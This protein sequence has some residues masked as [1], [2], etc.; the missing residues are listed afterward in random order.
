VPAPSTDGNG[1]QILTGIAAI[2]ASDIWAVG[3]G[4]LSA[5]QSC[6]VAAGGTALHWNGAQWSATTLAVPSGPN[7]FGLSLA[8]VTAAASNNV[9]AVGG[10]GTGATPLIEHWNG[11]AWSIVPGASLTTTHGLEGVAALP[12]G[13]VWAVGQS[14]LSNGSG[15]TIIEQWN[16]SQWAQVA[17]PSPGTITNELRAVAA[18]SSN[19]AWAVGSSA[20]G[21]LAERWDG[22]KWSVAPT[23]SL[24]PNAS[25]LNGVAATSASDAWAIGVQTSTANNQYQESGLIEHWNGSAWSIVPAASGAASSPLNAVAALSAKDVWAV[26]NDN[27]IQHWDGTKWSVSPTPKLTGDLAYG[28]QLQGVSARAAN[29]VWAVGG[30]PPHSCGGQSPVLIEHWNGS[31]WS[32]MPLGIQGTLYSVSADAANDAWAVGPEA[33][34]HWNGTSWAQVKLPSSGAFANA[35]LYSVSARAPN[36]IWAVGTG[37]A[38]GNQMLIAHWDGTTWSATPVKNPGLGMNKLASVAV[39]SPTEAWAVGYF[40]QFPYGEARQALIMRYG[41]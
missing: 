33:V 4:P 36:N 30:N 10:A 18:T 12:S 22:T 31:K 8:S 37:G 27:V 1:Q 25:Q 13:T 20:A 35:A 7:S 6:G 5:A 19:A 39:V 11:S 38:Q 34:L 14:L 17:S 28:G 26:G 3:N 16:G 24:A 32:V 41:G 2:S 15:P 9:W 23:P 40:C 21:T 29:D